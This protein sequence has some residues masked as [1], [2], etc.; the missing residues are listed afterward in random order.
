[1]ALCVSYLDNTYLVKTGGTWHLEDAPFKTSQVLRMLKRHPALS[2]KSV[3]DIGCG[4]GGVLFELER[5]MRQQVRLTGFDISPQAHAIS[6]GLGSKRCEFILGNPFELDDRFELALV[7]DVIEHV[8]DYLGFLRQC[9]AKA[10]WKMYHIPL[11][12]SASTILRGANRWDAVGHLHI[13]TVETA[14][15]AVQHTGQKVVDWFLTPS[16]LDRPYRPVARL[17]NVLRRML[18]VRFCSRLLGGYS[19]MILAR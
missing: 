10:D 8:E 16:G 3:C 4:S 5:Y 1:M 19:L 18:P 11:D 14:M 2:P 17:T 12:A 15:K 7:L 13:F 9:A 6:T